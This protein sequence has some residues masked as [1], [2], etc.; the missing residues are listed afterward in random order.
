[1][2]SGVGGTVK[3]V[4]NRGKRSNFLY[5]EFPHVVAEVGSFDSCTCDQKQGICVCLKHFE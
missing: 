4:F 1:M 3:A 5:F 2:S